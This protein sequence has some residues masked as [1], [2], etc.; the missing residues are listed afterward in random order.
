M[1]GADSAAALRA[2]TCKAI[3]PSKAEAQAS[4]VRSQY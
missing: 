2:A 3:V 4:H 1:E